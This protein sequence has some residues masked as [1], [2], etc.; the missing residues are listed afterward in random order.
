MG[1]FG[2][3]CKCEEMKK[4]SRIKTLCQF[5]KSDLE[6]ARLK[7][8]LLEGKYSSIM[9][10]CAETFDMAEAPDLYAAMT[11]LNDKGNEELDGAIDRLDKMISSLGDDLT[12]LK[13]ID[14][15]YHKAHPNGK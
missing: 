4:Y 14:D 2:G 5:A 8:T 9:D 7:S 10:K 13:E 3:E 6:S 12:K 11:Q 15:E 1:I